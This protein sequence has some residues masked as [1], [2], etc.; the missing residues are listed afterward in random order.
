VNG[1]IVGR[2]RHAVLVIV[3]IADITDAVVI[4]I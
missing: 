2:V 1:Q 4:D 3:R